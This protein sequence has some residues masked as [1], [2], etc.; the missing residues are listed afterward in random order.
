MNAWCVFVDCVLLTFTDFVILY[1]RGH[2]PF[3]LETQGNARE[4]TEKY[5]IYTSTSTTHNDLIN[6][7]G[8]DIPLYSVDSIVRSFD[9]LTKRSNVPPTLDN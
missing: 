6:N 3:A 9:S 5:H 2:A 4:R 8:F 7:N 1:L